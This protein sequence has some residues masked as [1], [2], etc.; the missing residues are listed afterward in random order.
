MPAMVGRVSALAAEAGADFHC[1]P[2][3]ASGTDGGSLSGAVTGIGRRIADG[4]RWPTFGAW[5][6]DRPG[7]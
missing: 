7:A 3:E 4:L 6:T 5:R 1:D 2:F